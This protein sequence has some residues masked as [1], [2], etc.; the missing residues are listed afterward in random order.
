[1]LIDLRV[2]PADYQIELIEQPSSGPTDLEFAGAGAPSHRLIVQVNPSQSAPWTATF[3]VERPGVAPAMSAIM[4]TPR[5]DTVCVIHRGTAFWVDTRRPR[6]SRSLIAEGPVM[7]VVPCP[8][9]GLLVI[10]TPWKAV[11]LSARGRA[12]RTP[13]I[14][15]DGFEIR[16][17]DGGVMRGLA[18]PTSMDPREFC[19]DLATGRLMGGCVL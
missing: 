7:F 18:D 10:A 8:H 15:L 13:R 4:S 5:P 17:I 2:F 1:M 16:E 9:A 3:V 19:V 11:G 12:W 6:P 14:A